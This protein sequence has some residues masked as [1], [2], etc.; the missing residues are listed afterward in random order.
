MRSGS[1]GGEVGKPAGIRDHGHGAFVP[2]IRDREHST[3]GS[4]RTADGYGCSPGHVTR[5]TLQHSSPAAPPAWARPRPAAS[6]PRAPTS[7]I[8]DRDATKGEARRERARRHLRRGRRHRRGRRCAAAVAA[9]VEL[10][11]LR[12]CIHC[13]G[14]GWAERTIN[15]DGDPHDL[16]TFR[17]IIEINLIGTFNVLRLAASGMSGERARRARRARRDRQ[18]RVGR[19]VR[20]SDRPGRVLGVEG[21][22]RRRSRSPRPAISRR[23]ASASARSRPAS[24]TRRC[25]AACPTTA[26]AQLA[27]SVLFPKR[28]GVRRRLRV[29]RDRARAQPLPERRGHPHG[30]RHPHA[31]EVARRSTAQSMAVTTRRATTS[32]CSTARFYVDDPHEKYTWMRANAPVYFDAANGVWG[33]A[34]A[35]P[36]CSARRRTRDVLERRRHP[37]RQRADP[38]DDRHGRPRALEAPQAREPRLHARARARQRARRSATSATRSSTGCASGASA[39]SCATS[40]RRCR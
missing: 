16:D 13:A 36:R 8:V 25:S 40:R 33:I 26:R 31:A 5:T 21:R 30:R 10:A 11:P 12:T 4:R 32:T 20:R 29:A 9:A 28:L 34:S 24:S 17:K 6:P 3:S 15:R 22:R 18:H 38:D 2:S 35:T 37:A 1:R 27:Q 7:S 23:S 39:T 19:R 14:V